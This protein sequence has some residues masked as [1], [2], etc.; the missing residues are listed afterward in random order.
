MVRANLK[1]INTVKKRRKDGSVKIHY[2]HRATKRPL[3]GS[4]GSPEFLNDYATA[5]QSQV[6]QRTGTLSGL[7]RD[8][9]LSPEFGKRAESTQKEYRRMLA[10]VETKFGTMPLA[11]LE[12]K[13]VRGDFMDW[14]DEV[15]T[16][17]GAREADNR[18]SVLSALLS[19]AV[20]RTR[21][22]QHHARGIARLHKSDRADKIWLPEHIE[23]FMKVAPIEM[24]RALILALHTGQRQGDLL[25]LAWTNY[26]GQRISLRQNKG[27]RRVYVACTPTLKRMLDGINRSAAVILTTKTSLPWTKRYFSE[28]WK[29]AC[30]AAGIADLH[31]H[32]LRG[33]A[34]TMLAE[35]GCSV[36][37]IAAITGHSLKS[38]DT[39]LEKYLSRTEHLAKSAMTKFENASSTDFANR[40]QTVDRAET[41]GTA[42]SLK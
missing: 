39:I 5:E 33:T 12:D 17:S 13:R 34:V 30:Q 40:L 32:D 14:R 9:T 2:Y 16:E 19:W 23:T 25:K 11:A 37:E 27:T 35:A 20:D 38:V 18:I 24:Q 6:T 42:K 36:P 41:R 31:F 8:F 3:R 26:D 22:G 7:I 10:K 4:P 21:I 29:A 15:A 28:H 1:G